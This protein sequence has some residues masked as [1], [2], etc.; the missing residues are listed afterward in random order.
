MFLYYQNI[1]YISYIYLF[2][3]STFK[4]ILMFVVP[5]HYFPAIGYKYQYFNKYMFRLCIKKYLRPRGGES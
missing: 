5:F 1:L 3:Y 2:I 4:S